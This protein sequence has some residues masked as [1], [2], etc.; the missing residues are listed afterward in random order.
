MSPSVVVSLSI[1]LVN[2]RVYV[3]LVFKNKTKNESK[4]IKNES[5]TCLK[6]VSYLRLVMYIEFPNNGSVRLTSLYIDT[7]QA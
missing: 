7:Y 4:M 5:M 6:T 2:A 1:N 3:V